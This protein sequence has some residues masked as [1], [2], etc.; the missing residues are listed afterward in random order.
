MRRSLVAP[1]SQNVLDIRYNLW[2]YYP[3]MHMQEPHA[4]RPNTSVAPGAPQDSAAVPYYIEIFLVMVERLIGYARHLDRIVPSK[5][6][7]PRFASLAMGWGTCDLRR[8]LM[9]IERGLRR[10]QVLQR[11]LL[12]RAKTGRDIEPTASPNPA[13]EAEID[14]LEFTFRAPRQPA[15][16]VPDPKRDPDHPAWFDMPT[17]KQLEAE[18][19][20]D[21]IARSLELIASD[22][23][24]ANRLFA[25]EFQ[26]AFFQ[27]RMHFGGN[28]QSFHE[29]EQRRLKAF[30][31]EYSRRPENWSNPSRDDA[32]ADL[33]ALLGFLPGETPPPAPG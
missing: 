2:S 31:K 9:H 4:T 1:C 29:T 24:I 32:R 22:L 14:A 18:I 10:A 16:R 7:H 28:F 26:T 13:A 27:A 33:R 25:D 30:E 15:R 17:T 3:T 12:A 6:E 11:Y 8:I 20:R 19:R 5:I 21:P 23:G